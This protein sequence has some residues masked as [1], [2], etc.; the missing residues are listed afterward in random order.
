MRSLI[1]VLLISGFSLLSCGSF[2]LAE[3][4]SKKSKYLF[5]KAYVI[6]LDRTPERYQTMKKLLDQLELPHE[7]FSAVDGY[8]VRLMPLSGGKVI[9]GT[10]LKNKTRS[11]VPNEKYRVLCTQN[12]KDQKYPL[13]YYYDYARFPKP[14]TPGELGCLCSHFLIWQDVAENGYNAA[15]VFEDDIINLSSNFPEFINQ[16]VTHMPQEAF[17]HLYVN[18]FQTYAKQEDKHLLSLECNVGENPFLCKVKGS[19]HSLGTFAYIINKEMAKKLVS[20]FQITGGGV[21]NTL[22]EKL[23]AQEISIYCGF[24]PALQLDHNGET[25]IIV[26]MGRTG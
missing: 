25:S 20:S 18:H 8:N 26:N 2:V 6:N 1:F 12:P 21:D 13:Y 10:E 23:D 11:L 17:V 5:D 14:V 24:P 7:R 16:I 15:L 22:M 4:S 19:T 9:T 3:E